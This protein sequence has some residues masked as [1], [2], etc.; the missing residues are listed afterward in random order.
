MRLG[1]WIL[2][3]WL[4]AVAGVAGGD[5]AFAGEGPPAGEVGSEPEALTEQQPL[6]GAAA[7][8]QTARA[9]LA[10]AGTATD[11]AARGA[12]VGRAQSEGKRLRKVLAQ[13]VDRARQGG[14]KRRAA[15]LGRLNVELSR[16]VREVDAARAG[17]E[18]EAIR[19]ALAAAEA[20][21]AGLADALAALDGAPTRRALGL[22]LWRTAA[23]EDAERS[24]LAG[25]LGA[26]LLAALEATEPKADADLI[27]RCRAALTAVA[28]RTPA[29]GVAAWSALARVAAEVARP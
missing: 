5:R 14:E 18:P 13:A 4:G 7:V 1:R 17:G 15:E 24:A 11:P 6:L 21:A 16:L 27:R 10:L 28:A 3:G 20:R 19:A 22:A 29:P 26:A 23:T 9:A 25:A 8:A 2:V 12:L